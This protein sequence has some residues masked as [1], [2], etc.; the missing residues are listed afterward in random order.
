MNASRK[1]LAKMLTSAALRRVSLEAAREV[2]EEDYRKIFQTIK[3][4]VG[5]LCSA[6]TLRTRTPSY[7]K[8]T[9]LAGSLMFGREPRVPHLV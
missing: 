4:M 5:V 1:A 3:R 7:A 2:E 9:T 6:N 8:P